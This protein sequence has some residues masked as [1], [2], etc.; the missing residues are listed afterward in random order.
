LTHIL[1]HCVFVT[2]AYPF[3]ATSHAVFKQLPLES[4]PHLGGR[5]IAPAFGDADQG[6]IYLPN[7]DSL[8]AKASI[9]KTLCG[10][11]VG[12]VW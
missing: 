6:A 12:L 2:T 5:M 9:V 8:F 1:K 10:R 7:F 4:S 11:F 3:V